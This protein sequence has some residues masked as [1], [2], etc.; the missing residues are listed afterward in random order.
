MS[1]RLVSVDRDSAYLLPPSVQEWLPSN[2]LARLVVSRRPLS[3]AGRAAERNRATGPP[4]A[5]SWLAPA[6][7]R[8]AATNESAS[9]ETLRLPGQLQRL[10]WTEHDA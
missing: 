8:T 6:P 7:G 9:S 4:N 3:P 10:R 5:R 2:H 1:G